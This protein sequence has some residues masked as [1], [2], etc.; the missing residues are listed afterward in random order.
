[1]P[2]RFCYLSNH[3]NH[4]GMGQFKFSIVYRPFDGIHGENDH[5]VYFHRAGW[6]LNFKR[7][8]LVK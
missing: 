7:K 1:M 2:E 6:I 3:S 8:G 5:Y 4:I